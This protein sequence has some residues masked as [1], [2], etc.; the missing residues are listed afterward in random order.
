MDINV[1]GKNT[2]MCVRLATLYFSLPL[3]ELDAFINLVALFFL[4]V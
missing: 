2:I 4:R 3:S 1:N